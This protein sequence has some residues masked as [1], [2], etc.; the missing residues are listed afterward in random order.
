MKNRIII[1]FSHVN[2][3]KM[4]LANKLK[5][6]FMF[7]K[8]FILI[9]LGILLFSCQNPGNND[10]VQDDANGVT[11]SDDGPPSPPIDFDTLYHDTNSNKLNDSSGENTNPSDI[12]RI[13][14]EMPSYKG[15]EE[16]MYKFLS[17]NIKYP[18]KAK[19]TGIQGN[20]IISFVVEKDGSISNVVILKDIGAGCGAEAA[21]VIKKM[22]KWKPG[23]QN[24]SIVRVQFNMPIRYTLE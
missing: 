2:V 3:G 7:G 24:G 19:E 9:V 23:K 22:P 1:L 13:V 16:A 4:R 17:D 18:Q 11:S 5:L 21:R 12:Y 14:E 10:S 20:V 15:G 6:G 8:P